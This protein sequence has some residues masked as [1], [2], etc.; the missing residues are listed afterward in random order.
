M[1]AAP[2]AIVHLPRRGGCKSVK[3]ICEQLKYLDQDEE[4]ILEFSERHGGAQMSRD[5]YETWARQWAEQTGHYYNG[6]SLYDG[7]QDLTTHI[8]V[9]FPSGTDPSAAYSSGRDWAENV[10]GSGRNGGEW[11]YI[12]AFHT[13]RPHPHLHVIVNRRSLAG[14]GEW[15]AISHRNRFINY[16][17]MRAA[18]VEAASGHGITLD[19][20]SREQ[21]G[22]QGRGPTTAEYRRK[23]RVEFRNHLADRIELVEPW[24]D[25]EEVLPELTGRKPPG[26]GGGGSGGSGINPDGSEQDRRSPRPA[27][28]VDAGAEADPSRIGVSRS[29]RFLPAKSHP[30]VAPTKANPDYDSQAAR[31]LHEEMER[32]EQ[33][34]SDQERLSKTAEDTDQKRISGPERSLGDMGRKD[35][36]LENRAAATSERDGSSYDQEAEEQIWREWDEYRARQIAKAREDREIKEVT[37][38]PG[39]RRKPV[40]SEERTSLTPPRHKSAEEGGEESNEPPRTSD[41]TR[42]AEVAPSSDRSSHRMKE[43]RG[44]AIRRRSAERAAAREHRNAPKE[45]RSKHDDSGT[46]KS[47]TKGAPVVVSAPSAAA[48]SPVPAERPQLKRSA[49]S[50]FSADIDVANTPEAAKRQRRNEPNTSNRRQRDKP[51]HGRARGRTR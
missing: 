9:S 24:D 44:E 19:A 7:E 36:S 2:Q 38:G 29:V 49:A 45:Q 5:D 27:G 41:D 46:G 40:P 30:Q 12:T 31:Q 37:A 28:R 43:T 18:L 13:N 1:S 14:R 17:T 10:F 33:N 50:A 22:L 11:D 25:E 48:N 4:V 47:P 20:S 51:L 34:S 16:D 15:L 39:R 35:I 8:I 6:E 26:T 3:R 32:A 42:A 21:R 23:A